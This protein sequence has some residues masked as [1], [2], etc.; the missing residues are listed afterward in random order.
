M[1]GLALLGISLAGGSEEGADASQYSVAF[2]LGAS[3][4]AAL[5]VTKLG[6]RLLAGAAA[7]GIAT[8]I[9]FAAG[10][11]GT[12]EAV[13]G[14]SARILFIVGLI[15]CYAVGTML[16]QAGFQRGS[17]LTAAGLATL[18]TNALPIGAGMTIFGEPLPDGFM[19]VP[20]VAAFLVVVAGAVLLA[21]RTGKGA[22][23][24][25]ARE[26]QAQ[27]SVA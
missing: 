4:L 24:E 20:R 27:P 10:D 19:S 2:W 3:G 17:A 23:A 6:P 1:G 9:L 13:D 11:V 14:G 15:A 8:G 12:K 22:A 7:Y 25:D 18:L 5:I 21:R 16:L 26:P